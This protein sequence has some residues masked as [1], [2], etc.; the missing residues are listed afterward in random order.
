MKIY[1]EY[2]RD[3]A[4]LLHYFLMHSPLIDIFKISVE[5]NIY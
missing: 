2:L 4:Q 5:I 1:N 3:D